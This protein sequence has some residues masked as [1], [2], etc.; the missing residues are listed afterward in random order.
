MFTNK[1]VTLLFLLWIL[2]VGACRSTDTPSPTDAPDSTAAPE[3]L[4]IELGQPILVPR[5][6]T[7]VL[8]AADLSL[9]FVDLLDESR[10]PSK[11]QCVEAGEARISI[12]VSQ[13]GAE[14]ETLEMNTNPPL[15]Q[16]VVT[17][18]AFQIQLTALDPYPEEIHQ[19]I[20]ARLYEATFVV[21][22]R[23]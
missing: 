17:F 14:A 16:D 2:T 19:R 23:P 3:E 15:K 1:A 20:S 9:T 21:T 13:N 7:A 8:P 5:G 4:T 11:V 12:R 18:G 22:E 10:C 6:E